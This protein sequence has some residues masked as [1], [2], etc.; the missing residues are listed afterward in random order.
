MGDRS[1]RRPVR[2]GGP[3]FDPGPVL[4]M[5]PSGTSCREMAEKIGATEP[6][7]S[8]WR[9][10]NRRMSPASADTAATRLG[11]HPSLLWP[12]WDSAQE[13]CGNGHR[14]A[15]QERQRPCD[16]YRRCA[17]CR[18]DTERRRGTRRVRRKETTTTRDG[19]T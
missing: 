17:A 1:G 12:D 5:F 8:Q 15:D 16:R 11:I 19:A 9:L 18:T 7:V 14:W 13:T 6:A 10:G 4:A 3:L 2:Q